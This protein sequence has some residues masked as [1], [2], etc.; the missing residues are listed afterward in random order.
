M[1]LFYASLFIF[2]FLCTNFL[3]AQKTINRSYAPEIGTEYTIIYLDTTNVEAGGAGNNQTWDFSNL[4]ET[5]ETF[6]FRYIDVSETQFGSSFPNANIAYTN[7]TAEVFYQVDNSSWTRW[8]VAYDGG[9]EFLTN[10]S[11]EIRFPMDL[12][13]S[14]TDTFD[15][16]IQAPEASLPREGEQTITYDAY[17]TIKTPSGEYSNVS[18]IKTE[19]E[20]DDSF[21]GTTIINRITTYS[22]MIEN[23]AYPIFSLTVSEAIIKNDFF[24]QTTVSKDCFYA[25]PGEVDVEVTTPTILGPVDGATDL[26]LPITLD[27][28]EVD[29][30]L[31]KGDE[32]TETITYYV[33]VSQAPTFIGMINVSEEVSESQ[34]E[35]TDLDPG[36][37]FYWRVKAM[38]GES[39][40]EWS[41]I[42]SF[43][44]KAA[45]EIPD[46]PTLN[47]PADGAQDI[48]TMPE[49]NWSDDENVTAWD[50][51]LSLSE[52]FET[53]IIDEEVTTNSYT[54]MTELDNDTQY[55]WRVRAKNESADSDWSD[56]FSFTTEPATSV[57]IKERFNIEVFPN[58]ATENL[59]IHFSSQEIVEYSIID[60]HGQILKNGILNSSAINVQELNKGTYLLKI[61]IGNSIYVEKLILQ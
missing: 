29:V 11:D 7:D 45:I 34:Y 37:N 27:W 38:L 10:P 2:T 24:E 20:I 28:E 8:G 47:S 44:T 59:T 15:G 50:F 25:V 14:Y 39:E 48:S 17:G 53:N 13:D 60:I 3:V 4:T 30:P 51:Q 1:K 46:T 6:S 18:R 49:F 5:G 42:R 52:Q 9:G 32:I 56:T 26:E 54:L 57:E 55:F 41:E 40:S 22:W 19:M 12:G 35:I 36:M 31:V 21:S 61:T 16:T 43:S 58:P 23:N 33:E